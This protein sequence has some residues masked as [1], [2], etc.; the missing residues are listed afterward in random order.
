[1]KQFIPAVTIELKRDI[2]RAKDICLMKVNELKRQLQ[3]Q[4]IEVVSEELV[5]SVQNNVFILSAKLLC[6]ENTAQEV[7]IQIESEAKNS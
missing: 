2:Q 5:G 7:E 3:S 6:H 1:M 4:E